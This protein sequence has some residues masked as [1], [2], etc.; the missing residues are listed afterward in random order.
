MISPANSFRALP[1]IELVSRSGFSLP[2][3][4]ISTIVRRPLRAHLSRESSGV[5]C[6][7]WFHMPS[8]V[9]ITPA[10]TRYDDARVA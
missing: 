5:W 10:A 9:R 1:A 7:R 2:Y 6:P 8:G 4:V 3:Q